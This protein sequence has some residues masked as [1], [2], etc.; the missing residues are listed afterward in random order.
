MP[1]LQSVNI[2]A[3]FTRKFWLDFWNDLSTRALHSAI[4]VVG[5]LLIYLVLRL[6]LYR[7]IDGLLAHLLAQE[8]R[9]GITEERAGRLQTLQ[10]L[11]KS[12]LSY[13]LFFVFGTL[14]L[15]AVGFDIAPV[16]TTAG[17]IGLAVGF[18]SQKLVKDVISGFFI[19]VDNLFVV[20]DTITIGTITG[21]VQEM[22]MRVT[23]IQDST[24]RVYIFSNGDIGTVTNMSRNPVEDYIEVNVGPNADL[25]QVVQ[26]L[27][28]AGQQLY[29][30]EGQ[31]LRAAP[32]VQGIT[33]FSATSVTVRVTVVSDPHDLPQEQMR[34]RAAARTALLSAQ[35]PIA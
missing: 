17:V 13:V 3:L 6:A 28:K 29:D 4:E 2:W 23:R 16:I 1:L 26:T 21:Q 35:I 5:I 10:G 12:V 25:N 32:H 22:G 19:V 14:F 20:G 7:L 15:E 33:A 30:Q 8:K 34:V 18:G 11:F 24:G 27:N 31:H 9:L